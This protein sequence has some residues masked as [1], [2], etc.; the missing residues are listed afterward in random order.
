MFGRLLRLPALTITCALM[1]AC[2]PCGEFTVASGYMLNGVSLDGNYPE[3]CSADYGT[4]GSWNLYGDNTALIYLEPT[5][6]GEDTINTAAIQMTVNVPLSRMMPGELIP[7]DELYG[8]AYILSPNGNVFAHAGLVTGEIEVVA[9]KSD[10]TDPCAMEGGSTWDGPTY[11][12]RWDLQWH[13]SDYDGT[14]DYSAV[15]QDAI[16]FDTFLSESCGG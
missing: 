8:E 12:L 3:T 4:W 1:V 11:V 5:G 15:G 13:G 2:R 9:D 16:G 10:G 14:Y 6:Q 7:V